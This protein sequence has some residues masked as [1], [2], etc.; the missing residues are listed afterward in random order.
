MKLKKLTVSTSLHPWK[1]K[2]VPYSNNHCLSNILSGHKQWLL[3]DYINEHD[4]GESSLYQGYY[5][6]NQLFEENAIFLL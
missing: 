6:S 3:W 5:H 4:N 1:Y 2:I